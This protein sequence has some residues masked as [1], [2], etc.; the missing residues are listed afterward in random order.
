MILLVAAMGIGLVARV[1]YVLAVGR[2][3]HVGFDAI[4]YELQGSTL[5]K[6]KGYIDPATYFATGRSVPTA[7]FPPLWPALLAVADRLGLDTQTWNQLVGAVV[8]T[9][10]VGLTGLL[11]RRVAGPAWACWPPCWW[12]PVRC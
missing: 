8:G 10:T 9:I 12:P 6:G 4:W 3:V 11:G 5:A 7:N 2:H 1:A